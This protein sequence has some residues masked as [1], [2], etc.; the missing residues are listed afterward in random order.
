RTTQDALTAINTPGAGVRI[1]YSG[2]AINILTAAGQD[3]HRTRALAASTK[4]W[5]RRSRQLWTPCTPA[6]QSDLP[7]DALSP[8]C[9]LQ[10]FALARYLKMPTNPPSKKESTSRPGNGPSRKYVNF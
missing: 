2:T 8:R 10:R 9:R 3:L 6:I 4:A 7:G 5:P 1:M